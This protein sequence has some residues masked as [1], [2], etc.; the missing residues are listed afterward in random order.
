M[1]VGP[2][3]RT[4][5][6]SLR[7]MPDDEMLNEGEDTSSDEIDFAKVDE[8]E[9]YDEDLDELD[10]NWVSRQ[11]KGHSSDATLSCPACFVTVCLD[12]QRH[13]K[14]PNRFRAMFVQNCK[15]KVNE[16]LRVVSSKSK[17]K[18]RHD[19][20]NELSR[21]K[22][23]SSS[24]TNVD[25]SLAE[26]ASEVEDAFRSVV[27]GECGTEVGVLDSEEV[28]HFFNIIPSSS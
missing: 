5:K 21:L 18:L 22:S 23:A 27:C 7:A 13:D 14:Y 12:S 11:R 26:G 19:Q 8:P 20:L 17:H 10:A 16:V 1:L 4:S 9:W 6:T 2:A 28:Y 25:E 3:F 24:A 15:V